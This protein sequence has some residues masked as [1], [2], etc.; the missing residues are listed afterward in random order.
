MADKEKTGSFSALKGLTSSRVAELYLARFSYQSILNTI[1]HDYPRATGKQVASFVS[2]AFDRYGATKESISR[3]R[4]IKNPQLPQVRSIAGE[5]T[6]PDSDYSVDPSAFGSMPAGNRFLYS[7]VVDISGEGDLRNI[8][9]LSPYRLTKEQIEQESLSQ[10]YKF[11]VTG[12]E[13][14]TSGVDDSSGL[15][16]VKL[17][18]SKAL[19]L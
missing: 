6:I 9:I 10:A 2:R 8:N 19:F 3:G 11:I 1:Q 15:A 16:F 12:S 17:N 7:T 14:F 5:T 4:D 13:S 18:Y